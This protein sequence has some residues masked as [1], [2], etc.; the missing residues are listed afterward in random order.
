[1]RVFAA[2][3]VRIVGQDKRDVQFLLKAEKVGLNLLL[4]G[5]ALVLNLKVEVS[6][7]EDVLV[8]RGSALG[9]FIVPC[10]QF[11]AQLAGKTAGKPNQALGI[12]GEVFLAH[13]G[14]TVE[15]VQACFTGEADQ[16]A[17]AL[18]VLGQ[19]QQ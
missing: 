10:Q 6:A 15:T 4:F 5:E 18:F 3:V 19:N 11:F 7:T 17:V 9:L 12:V 16:V 14:L 13:A 8:L 2:Q 1:M